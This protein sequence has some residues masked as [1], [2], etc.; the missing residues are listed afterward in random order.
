[1]YNI[2]I[3]THIYTIMYSKT[4]KSCIDTGAVVFKRQEKTAAQAKP[5]RHRYQFYRRKTENH[6]DRG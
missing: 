5:D 3:Y 6:R 4:S 2:Y 1:M